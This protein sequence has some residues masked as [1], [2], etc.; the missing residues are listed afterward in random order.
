MRCLVLGGRGFV[1]QNLV[2]FLAAQGKFEKI[3]VF[4]RSD[5]PT[6]VG[7]ATIEHVTGD[8]AG[9]I[10]DAECLDDIDVVFHLISTTIPK[11]SNDDP[12]FDI[13]SNVVATVRLLEILKSKSR[14]PTV[15]FVSSG[16]TVYGDSDEQRIAETHPTD[17]ICSYGIHKLAIE[18]YLA[19]YSRLHGLDFRVLRVSNPYGLR[20]G[21]Q[22]QQGVI[23]IFLDKVIRDEVIEIW[24]D[25]SVIRDYIHI[26]DVAAAIFAASCYRGPYRVFNIGCGVGTSLNEILDAIGRVAG[27][28]VRRKYLEARG[29]DARSNVL[30]I[31]LAVAELGWAPA[32]ALQ[33]GIDE[34][35]HSMIA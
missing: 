16:G 27:K 19:V 34:L 26:N 24:G 3:F 13:E 2:R 32:R 30:D 18:K 15:I 1:G 5:D 11:T 7:A 9:M 4:D 10:G 31:R 6:A 21:H 28:E 14:K 8:F 35:Y 23:P 17:P 20:G 22:R 29:F 33:S 25:G 12:V